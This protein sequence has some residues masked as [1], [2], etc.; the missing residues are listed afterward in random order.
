MPTF[1]DLLS[2][3]IFE[4]Y[5]TICN[6]IKPYNFIYHKLVSNIYCHEKELNNVCLYLNCGQL[7]III[8]YSFLVSLSFLLMNLVIFLARTF[9]VVRLIIYSS[10]A[11][12]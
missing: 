3:T 1:E 9:F 8:L 11:L 6:K 7:N 4:I 10:S 2:Y 12:I 5:F